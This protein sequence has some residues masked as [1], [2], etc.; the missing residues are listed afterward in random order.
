MTANRL[1]LLAS[2]L[3]PLLAGCP[4]EGEAPPAVPEIEAEPEG[5]VQPEPVAQAVDPVLPVPWEFCAEDH[6]RPMF[7]RT[8]VPTG[9]LV[10][11]SGE[12]DDATFVPDPGH[13]WL[14]DAPR[15]PWMGERKATWVQWE[16]FDRGE[17]VAT[18]EGW[19]VILPAGYYENDAVYVPDPDH[20]WL[21][22]GLP[23]EDPSG[24]AGS[25]P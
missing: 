15:K 6:Q 16:Q 4:E 11:V 5:S 22:E 17:R 21:A 7:S 18:P 13:A 14:G 24:E 2:A 3:L 23:A 19:L 12:E 8:P 10:L 9:W 1:V 20:R 25:S